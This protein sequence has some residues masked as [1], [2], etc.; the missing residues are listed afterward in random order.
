[1]SGAQ[2]A[3]PSPRKKSKHRRS[4]GDG[5]GDGDRPGLA[6]RQCAHRLLSAI[7]DKSTPMDALT[8]D[9]HGHPTYLALEPRDRSLV[10][11]ILMAALRH[12]GDL[13]AVMSDFMDRPLPDGALSLRAILHVAGAQILF[14]DIPSHSAVD[15]AVESANRDPRNRRFASLVN[16]VT[17]RLA[18]EKQVRLDAMLSTPQ[19]APTWFFS[20]LQEVYGDE[21]ARRIFDIHRHPAPIDITLKEASETVIDALLTQA[22]GVRL[23]E[24]NVRLT[25]RFDVTQLPGFEEGQWWVQDFAASIPAK[26]FGN[27]DGMRMLDLC[28]AP[29]GKTAQ[30]LAMGG[31]VTA[32]E[33]SASR[34]RRLEENLLRL[35]LRDRCQT[36]IADLFEFSPD[37]P[38]DGVLLDA[39]CSSTGTVR[40]HPD[41]PWTK[42]PADIEKL[43]SLQSRMLEKAAK[44]VAPGGTLVFSN[45]SLDPLEGEDVAKAF[46]DTHGNSFELAPVEDRQSGFD[47]MMI[48]KAGF[49]RTT[50]AQMA[51][52]DVSLAGMDGFFAARFR[53]R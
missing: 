42:S 8:D 47:T 31:H 18:R 53:K 3:A 51:N 5:D 16:A 20:R 2:S 27:V 34:A 48:D 49:M 19:H 7:V 4:G 22:S 32:L 15:L 38:F 44:F 6:A 37:Q 11:A 28:A 46:I 14:L 9:Q 17:R 23:G 30:L 10:R 41:V 12:R 25:G 45:C 52:D 21:E 1:M 39:P 35:G 50:P 40:R 36:A 43:A 24:K 13:A 33:K 29:G 26:L